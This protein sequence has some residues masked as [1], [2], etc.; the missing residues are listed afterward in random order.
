MS[1]TVTCASGL[2]AA[3]GRLWL[4]I[5]LF[6]YAVAFASVVPD[7]A[8]LSRTVRRR[9]VS[10][11]SPLTHTTYLM[12]WAAWLVYGVR[13]AEGPVILS[14]AVSVA[15]TAAMVI[16]LHRL[17]ALPRLR[18]LAL[19]LLVFTS[20]GALAWAAPRVG[21]VALAAAELT[22]FL[23]QLVAAFKQDDLSGL[24]PTAVVWELSTSL[25]WVVY[26]VAAGIA[27]AGVFSAVQSVLLTA[28][29][30]RLLLFRRRSR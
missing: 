1:I 30:W 21:G 20:A 25:G 22:F 19:P 29:A 28:V 5:T 8:Q 16:L 9:T 26:T 3:R 10:G 23:P 24:S 7:A 2:H 27:E 18:Q 15:V 17:G 11:L 14:S 13:L 4:M 6:G 12:S